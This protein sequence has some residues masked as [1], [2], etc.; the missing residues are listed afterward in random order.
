MLSSSGHTHRLPA[1]EKGLEPDVTAEGTTHPGLFRPSDEFFWGVATSGYQAEGG[2]NGPGEPLNNWGW[3]ESNGDVVPSGRTSDFWT[4]AHEDFARCRDMGLNAFRMSIE[5]SRIQPTRV[6]HPIEGLAPGEPPPPFDERA[7]YS[8][9]QRIADCRAHGLEPIITLH[10]FVQPAWLGLDAW[11]KP[12]TV[13]HFL[14]FVEHTLAYFLRTL[15]HDFGCAP[16]RWFITI[17]EPNLLAFNHYSYRIFPS[18]R[19]IGVEPT[20]QCLS[21]LLEAHVRAYRLI[22]DIYARSGLKPMVSFNNY[23]SDL[24]WTDAAILDLLFA[25]A[26]KVPRQTIRDD[27]AERARAFDERFKAAKLFPMHGPRYFLS[28]W[29]KRAH[30]SLAKRGFNQPCWSRLISLL[31]ERAEVPLDYIAFDYYDPF[32][33]H[34]IR[35][36]TWHDFDRR[37][38]SFRDWV[39]ESVASKWWDWHMLPEGLA[40]FVKHLARYGLPLLIAENGMA[41][42]R[43]PDNRPFRRRDNLARSHYLREHIRVVTR[44]VERGQPLIGYLHWSLFD[45]YEWGSFAPRFGLFSLDYTVYPTRHA[46]D[47]TGDNASATYAGEVREARAQLAAAARRAG[48]KPPS[49]PA[50]SGAAPATNITATRES[51]I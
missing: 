22:H 41:L 32:I 42:R 49:E 40:F 2:Y 25:P 13:D 34:A 18:G 5:W 44:L 28:Q 21:H 36:P 12:E 46:V 15:P 33:A 23:S 38:R 50:N 24:Y 39:L 6:L 51:N 48:H 35:W 26:R 7:L 47:V 14:A 3:A 11:L 29:I 37:K 19:P 45:N 10:H 43:L 16:P 1:V 4:L 27:L 30:H 20:V 9:A 8:Y 31:Y 17:N